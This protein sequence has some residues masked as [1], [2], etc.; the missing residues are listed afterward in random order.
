MVRVG[1]ILVSAF[2][3]LLQYLINICGSFMLSM[4]LGIKPVSYSGPHFP[5][6]WHPIAL[7]LLLYF[8]LSTRIHVS[9]SSGLGDPLHMHW[10]SSGGDWDSSE[11][12]MFLLLIFRREQLPNFWT[13]LSCR[14]SISPSQD[15]FF[16]LDLHLWPKWQ[17]WGEADRPVCD[18]SNWLHVRILRSTCTKVQ[19][20]E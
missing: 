8:P 11:V 7:W 14:L 6:F 1:L 2:A 17:S 5:N 16:F 15:P 3:S 10:A 4:W 20:T 9:S 13:H 12:T 18:F 19:I